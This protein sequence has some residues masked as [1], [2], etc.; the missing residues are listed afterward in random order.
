MAVLKSLLLA[1]L[2]SAGLV[3]ADGLNTR[4]KAAGKK[5][6]GTEISISV[7]NDGNANNIAKNSQ[8]FGQYTCENE[9]KFDALEPARNSFNYGNADK[10]VAQAQAN[11]QIMRCHALIWHS[12]VPAWVTN[13]RFNKADL[14]SILKNHIANVVGHYKG[15]CYAWDVVNEA[16]NEDGSY[17]TSGSVW[18]STIGSE[19]IPMA[20][21]AAAAADPA[22]KL[23]YNDYNCD[24]P[25]AKATGAQN[26]IKMVKAAGAP[27]HGF[28]MQG[29]MTTGQVGSAS[30]YVSHMQSFANLGVEVAYTELDIATPSSNPNFQQQATDYA[31]IVSACK[32]VA[33]CIGITTWG[34]TDKHTW[35]SNSAP[36]IWDANLQKKAAYNAIL[37]AWGSTSGGGDNGGGNTGGGD[38]GGGNTGGGGCTVAMYGQCGGNGYS[39]CKTC[40]S[41]STCKFS[42]D[43]YSQCLQVDS[44]QGGQHR[45]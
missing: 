17:R 2:A 3:A 20:F 7:M 18:G 6:F 45:Y 28:G 12:Q 19:F 15:K 30:Q 22:A 40:A 29:H 44:Y 9:M 16:L 25:G 21:A 26:L 23:Y 39:G 36:L 37:N 31:T 4:A 43:W 24:R 13:G 33:A 32:Q 35:I 42:N 5:Y 8:D 38:N 10:I 27:I 41:G 1:S 34:F 11:G 14:S